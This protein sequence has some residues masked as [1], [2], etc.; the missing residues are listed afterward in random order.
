VHKT[1]LLFYPIPDSFNPLGLFRT[2][3]IGIVYYTIFGLW[4]VS[5]P[6]T[7]PRLDR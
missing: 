6:A 7:Y 1:T 5:P 4:T 2:G 3:S